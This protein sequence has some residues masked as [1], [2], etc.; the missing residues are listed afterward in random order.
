MDRQWYVPPY[1]NAGLRYRAQR[2]KWE[3]FAGVCMSMDTEKFW[4]REAAEQ[5]A[6]ELNATKERT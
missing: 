1:R 4:T 3:D 6:A 5:R 2:V